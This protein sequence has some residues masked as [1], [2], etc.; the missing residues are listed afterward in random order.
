[1]TPGRFAANAHPSGE[2]FARFFL[3]VGGLLAI[4]HAFLV[5]PFEVTDEDRHLWRA[6]GVSDLDFVSRPL[7][8]IP[9]SFLRLHERFS[10]SLERPPSKKT[11]S[12]L[13]LGSWLRQ[14]L[15]GDLRVSV[16]N[17]VAS[18]YSFVP[19]V[20][21]A[22][23]LRIG[24]L[25]HVPPLSQ[26]YAGRLANAACYVF[27]VYLALLTLPDFQLPLLLIALTPMS[28]N[29]AASFSA[30]AVTLGIAAFTTAVIF[31]LAFDEKPGVLWPADWILIPAMLAILTLCKF[32]VWICLLV[33][34]I[35]TERFGSW[36]RRAVSSESVYWFPAR[37]GS[38]GRGSTPLPFPLILTCAP[39][40]ERHSPVTSSF[41][42]RTP[43]GFSQPY[44]PH[45]FPQA[46]HGFGSLS[47][48]SDGSPSPFRGYCLS[49][50]SL[51][52]C[53]QPAR[54]RGLC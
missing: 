18:L 36:K 25:F 19:Y 5:P 34:L 20:P 27:M 51:Y 46:G 22:L 53:W 44:R 52:S 28:L 1:M 43:S 33:L 31:K 7:T 26:F 14:P 15:Q 17:Q 13:E 9:A 8:R 3:I 32:N 23:V 6:Y 30:D 40:T 48:S 10:P 2:R 47:A 16:E 21:A 54:K 45:A 4:T 41:F 50:T 38:A 12:L 24:R 11:V 39:V 29:L 49:Y 42:W 37:L 35:P